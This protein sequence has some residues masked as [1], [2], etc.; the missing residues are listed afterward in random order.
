MCVY[1]FVLYI[2]I[3]KVPSKVVHFY[4]KSSPTPQVEQKK[5]CK[6][7][8]YTHDSKMCDK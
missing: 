3:V 2:I 7:Q 6:T 4:T 5:V 1:I 8:H